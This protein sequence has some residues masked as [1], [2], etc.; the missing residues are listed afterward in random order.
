MLRRSA[1]LLLLPA[2]ALGCAT[3]GRAPPSREEARGTLDAL[4]IELDAAPMPEGFDALPPALRALLDELPT[5]DKP[6]LLYDDARAAAATEA[7]PLGK[8]LRLALPA[9]PVAEGAPPASRAEVLGTFLLGLQL[10][11]HGDALDVRALVLPKE[12]ATASATARSPLARLHARL[13]SRCFAPGAPSDA[14]AA[15]AQS[16]AGRLRGEG[17]GEAS[18]RVLQAALAL[19]DAPHRQLLERGLAW[20]L[21]SRSELERADAL[22]EVLRPRESPDFVAE[23]E[24]KRP[25]AQRRRELLARPETAERELLLARA[26]NELDLGWAA[27]ARL[28]RALLNHPDDARLAD[29]RFLLSAI[30]RGPGAALDATVIEAAAARPIVDARTWELRAFAAC[31]SAIRGVAAGASRGEQQSVLGA[32]AAA[33]EP[34][35][36]SPALARDNA[37]LAAL[38]SL[39]LQAMR[40]IEGA[41]G[42]TLDLDAYAR[43]TLALAARSPGCSPCWLAALPVA[44]EYVDERTEALLLDPPVSPALAEQGSFRSALLLARLDRALLLALVQQPDAER[45]RVA[46]IRDAPEALRV[47]ATSWATITETQ[48]LYQ[49]GE[50]PRPEAGAR[51]AT[52]AA[53][54]L[55]T[56]PEAQFVAPLQNFRLVGLMHAGDHEAAALLGLEV[57]PDDVPATFPPR[58]NALLAAARLGRRPKETAEALA[59][60]RTLPLPAG[61]QAE[62]GAGQRLVPYLEQFALD[63]AGKRDAF[64]AFVSRMTPA[65]QRSIALGLAKTLSLSAACNVR[66][67]GARSEGI[68]LGLVMGVSPWLL[69]TTV[70]GAVRF[71]APAPPRP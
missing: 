5:S 59:R 66:A 16:F 23:W 22:Y 3:T 65:D 71:D 34:L 46:A 7:S 38:L 13:V 57:F 26:E 54:A 40:G 25:V 58:L 17:D 44:A 1:L 36:A 48:Q 21:L 56:K 45:Y 63:P 4:A 51:I 31:L 35:A 18:E 62:F 68:Q 24:K 28:D 70:P 50:L 20:T 53:A 69:G 2:L 64:G 8:A 6:A 15:G 42:A 14:L 61:A 19:V 52:A 43:A 12:P 9:L 60:L 55:A 39:Q 67:T 41:P 49:R 47:V 32:I 29:E 10:A 33:F 30:E 27:L 37:P 11:E